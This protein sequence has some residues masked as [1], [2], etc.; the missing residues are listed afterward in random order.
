M[1]ARDGASIVISD[2][3]MPEMTGVEFL[4]N[5]RKLFPG[6]VRIVVSGDDDRRTLID[7]INNAGIHKFLSKHWD[8]DRLRAAVREAF[9]RR[10]A[11]STGASQT[12]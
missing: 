11:A 8:P 2:H 9:D 6:T 12:A 4:S 3:Q 1:L 5:V 7:A 10:Q